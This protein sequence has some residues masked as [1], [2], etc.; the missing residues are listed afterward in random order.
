MVPEYR[1]NFIHSLPSPRT[2]LVDNDY[3]NPLRITPTVGLFPG[4]ILKARRK[5]AVNCP[6]LVFPSS[7]GGRGFNGRGER[8]GGSG[9]R[10]KRVGRKEE[11]GDIGRRLL[12]EEGEIC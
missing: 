4:W 11:R 10:G 9:E 12:T 1:G 3:Y 6:L 7:A 2:L 5:S 8:R